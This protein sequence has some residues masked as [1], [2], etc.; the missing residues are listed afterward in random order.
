VYEGKATTTFGVEA[1]SE[2]SQSRKDFREAVLKAV[3]DYKNE[4]S[5]EITTETDSFSE[6]NE[7]GT[8]VNSNDELAVTYLFYELQKRYRVSEQLYRV[9]PVVLVAQEVPSP[10]QITPAWVIAND[11]I[12]N[13]HLLDDSFRST[14]GYIANKSVGDDFALRELRK[15][16][17][18]QRNLVETLR[19]E[20]SAASVEADNRYKALE[21]A[22]SDRIDEEHAEA[23]DGLVN[24]IA[25]FFGRGPGIPF[26]DDEHRG[27]DPEAAKARELAAKDAH[28]YAME[29]AEKVSTALR[30]E[31][32]TLHALTDDYNKAMQSRLDEETKVRRLLVHIRNNIFYY[33]QAIWSMEPPDQRYL[34]PRRSPVNIHA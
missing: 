11:W 22:I 12:L 23:T 21:K 28:Q 2:S 32:N 3:Q 26:V 8:I 27:Q 15:N 7:S 20:F 18:Q 17:R 24:D 19:I 29:K 1:A 4:V 14:L 16:L 25:D 13:R 31:V 33:M 6:T 9:M 5:T 34:N 10:D 30:Q